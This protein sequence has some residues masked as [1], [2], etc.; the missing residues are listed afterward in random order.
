[1]ET[2]R[3]QL[4]QILQGGTS[5][6]VAKNAFGKKVIPVAKLSK[7]GEAIQKLIKD[8]GD[9]G[10]K[11]E[12]IAKLVSLIIGEK[13]KVVS[14][15]ADNVRF[16]KYCC[17]YWIGSDKNASYPQTTAKQK[18]MLVCYNG[19]NTFLFKMKGGTN[20]S[21]DNCGVTNSR[22]RLK[23]AT[24]VDIATFV[25]GLKERTFASLCSTIGL[26]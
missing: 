5:I 10:C 17:L 21:V 20:E 7:K 18:V 15:S 14:D 26:K 19:G 23:P 25:E 6:F 3:E 13:I 8:E 22:D 4:I 1:M 9:F 11:K 12:S 24:Y 16:E 2:T